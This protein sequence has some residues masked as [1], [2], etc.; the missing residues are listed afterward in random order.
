[1]QMIYNLSEIEHIAK[2]I[3][4]SSKSNILLF[5]GEMG[6]G[7][8]TLVKSLAKELGVQETA[9]SPTF[10]IVN[11]YI[12]DN[13]KVLYHFD[14]YRLE[15]EEEALDLGFEEYLTQGDWIFIEW[16]EKITSFLPLNAQKITITTISADKRQLT[17]H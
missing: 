11:E 6:A 1:M 8:T 13:N 9:S 15:K 7:K 17:L 14:F 4:S 10:S 12:S 16:P 5:Y 3:I 2:T